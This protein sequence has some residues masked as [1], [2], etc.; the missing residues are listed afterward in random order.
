MKIDYD[1][2]FRL[3][4]NGT[5]TVT[6]GHCP[7]SEDRKAIVR[8]NG[9][10]IKKY[11]IDSR[12]Y[13][14]IVSSAV[15]LYRNKVNNIIFLTLTFP[16][17]ITDKDANICFSKFM[18]NLNNNY[19]VEN[20][21]A[22][23]ELTKKDIPHFHLLADYPFIDIRRINSAWCNTFPIDIPGSKNAVRLPKNHKSVVKNLYRCIK[24]ICKYF[25]KCRDIENLTRCYFISHD[26][27]SRPVDIDYDLAEKL[28]NVYEDRQFYYR[29]CVIISLKGCLID[30]SM[31]EYV[32]NEGKEI[33][34]ERLKQQALTKLCL[35]ACINSSLK[36][37]I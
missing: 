1:S 6:P 9:K 3:Y 36:T 26:V 28:I 23:K 10:R 29:Y 4:E 14:H 15:N 17:Y 21:V 33:T 20:Y 22:V 35:L 13:R 25:T 27:C 19:D 5:V 18:N 34:K 8:E 37:V 16:K 32:L 12:I 7:W 31:M 30:Y 24:Y 11:L 2:R